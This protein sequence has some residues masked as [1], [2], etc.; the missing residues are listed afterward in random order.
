MAKLKAPL[1]SMGATG[2]LGKTMVF[3][4]WKGLNVVREFVVPANPNTVPQQ[5]QRG[6]VTDAV[7]MIH[8]AQ[9]AAE[10]P[11]ND[12]DVMA[13]SAL[14]NLNGSPRTWFN[15]VVKRY[16]NQHVASKQFAICRDGIWSGDADT[17]ALEVSFTD[18]GS[19]HVTAGNFHYGTS[20]SALI[21]SVAA[22]VTTGLAQADV[23]T[24]IAGTKYYFQFRPTAHDDFDG[25]VSGIYSFTCPAGS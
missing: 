16:I 23:T 7:A 2:Q 20:P 10:H 19:N 21:Y 1:L 11:L 13:Y 22:T 4:P 14:A 3:F 18:E 17:L 24:M 25:V 12:Q 9:V 6:F 15:E 8:A 5:T